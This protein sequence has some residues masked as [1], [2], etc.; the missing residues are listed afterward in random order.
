MVTSLIAVLLTIGFV[1]GSAVSFR[2]PEIGN[3]PKNQRDVPDFPE[4]Y[5]ENGELYFQ[6]MSN[7][8]SSEMSSGS[9]S[10]G[11]YI[12]NGNAPE[13]YTKYYANVNSGYLAIRSNGSYNDENVIGKLY[14]GDEVYVI[15]TSTGTYWYCYS[16]SNGVY[17]Y[18]N[19]N[20]LVS[21]RPDS[22]SS[23]ASSDPID[24]DYEIWIVA[25]D[26][27][28][29]ISYLALRSDATADT[30][31]EID[32]LYNNDVV[33]V[34]N[35]SYTSYYETYWYVYA[36]TIGKWGYVNSNYIWGGGPPNSID[37][38]VLNI[39]DESE[40]EELGY[41]VKYINTSYDNS[42]SLLAVPSQDG[43]VLATIKGS[44]ELRIYKENF[45]GFENDTYWYVYVPSSDKWGYVESYFFI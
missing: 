32:K 35:N 18:V 41:A 16:P 10:S 3:V 9:T 15:D 23:R 40:F 20:Y 45:C 36:P 39:V 5:E 24:S 19:S 30:D 44:D 12:G 38:S 42:T 13:N 6:K 22:S 21:E 29:D 4:L 28:N 8:V 14:T 17:G 33:Y 11:Y 1:W 27:Q 31:N 37:T 25:L 34:Y 2:F 26:N 7:V 43:K